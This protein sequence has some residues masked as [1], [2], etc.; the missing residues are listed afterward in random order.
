MS[1]PIDTKNHPAVKA[2]AEHQA[3]LNMA[4]KAFARRYLRC[5]DSAWSMIKNGTY[6]SDHADQWIE[7]C[8]S[9]LAQLD[10]EQH[11][12][13]S[14]PL[15]NLS[16][17][18]AAVAAVKRCANEERNRLV[19]FLGDTG[20][21]KTKLTAMLREAYLSNFV[22]I[23]ASESWRDGYS[24]PVFALCEA[25]DIGDVPSSVREAEQAVIDSLAVS[26]RIIGVDEGHHCGKAALNL[27]K[28]ILNRTRSRVVVL[29]M[30][31]LWDLMQRKAW[32]EASQLRN[33]TYAKI[34]MTA[35]RREDARLL[36]A[37]RMPGFSKLGDEEK[38][39]LTMCC[40][41]ANK[42]GLYNTLQRICDEVAEEGLSA[43]VD[44]VTAAIT[45]VEAL[46]S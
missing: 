13:S 4:N 22:A 41:A 44:T 35:V 12:K 32:Y 33:R 11:E 2:L 20:A 15:L 31:Q 43:N 17:A 27:L 23:E 16:D 14:G 36:L 45:R 40:E 37:A 26:P 46:R 5:S 3:R 29:A 38:A 8:T 19:V 24:G 30:P 25:L 1:T 7:K 10:D 9:A 21:G 39:V 42:F 34:V 18:R 6:P 28:L